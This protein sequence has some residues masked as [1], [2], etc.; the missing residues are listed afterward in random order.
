MK[1]LDNYTTMQIIDR[2]KDII[3]EDFEDFICSTI[4]N[5]QTISNFKDSINKRT[6]INTDKKERQKIA[7]QIVKDVLENSSFEYINDNDLKKQILEEII[8]AYPERIK[9]GTKKEI[10]DLILNGK[11]IEAYE[12]P[13]EKYKGLCEY[14]IITEDEPRTI[15]SIHDEKQRN[16]FKALINNVT[17]AD[18]ESIIKQKYEKTVI[19]VMMR[20]VAMKYFI[21]KKK[22]NIKEFKKLYENDDATSQIED[23]KA[24]KE[25]SN[26]IKEYIV[27]NFHFIDK[28][29]LLLNTASK[30]MLGLRVYSGEQINKVLIKKFDEA[31]RKEKI[32]NSILSLERIYRELIKG[33]Y[34][35]IKYKLLDDDGKII[36]ET[37]AKDIKEFLSRCTDSKYLS[38]SY[39]A[40]LRA[41]L[42]KGEFPEN[43]EELKI[44]DIG[45]E[46]VSEIV[47]N[48]E[49]AEDKEKKEKL[50]TSANILVK[51][52]LRNT[53][54]KKEDIID[55]YINGNA[56]LKL[57]ESMP[58]EEFPKEYFD[59]RFM[60]LFGEDVYL[61]TEETNAKLNRYGKL[62][63]MLR[64]QNH[65][66]TTTDDL[67]EKL[68][69]MFGE[70]FIP[71]II[72]ELYKTGVTNIEEAIQWLGGEFIA[73]QYEQG[74]I[75]PVDIREIYN[76]RI[77]SLEELAKM[78]NLLE[79]NTKKFMI[80]SSIF[81]E[82]DSMEIRQKLLEECMKVEDS[83]KGHSLNNGKQ[84]GDEENDKQKEKRYS[85]YITDP[86]ARF[87]LM[88]LLDRDYAYGMTDDG[89]A[90]VYLPDF[91]KVII[92]K[93]L[94]K[95]GEPYYGAATYVVDEKYF[96][97]NKSRVVDTNKIKRSNLNEDTILNGVDK[98][99]H[100]PTGWGKGIKRVLGINEEN[101]TPEELQ[102]IEEA[103]KAVEESRTKIEG[104]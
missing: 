69:N 31:E 34:D 51:Y 30:L 60:E 93:M 39:I 38:V 52:L 101:R 47:K 43:L 35:N 70:E 13:S 83:E 87:L 3:G 61:D 62:Y 74:T 21:D 68:A 89:H 53:D 88:Q 16:L 78:I 50:L 96:E 11:P 98:I 55:L 95:Y 17:A 90:V 84:N 23:E 18:I 85:K 26:L 86:V 7:Y 12:F 64:E 48:Y 9:T 14:E 65:I 103:I 63:S 58:L 56:N 92:E 41:N 72:G 57:I 75:K 28:E 42:A 97:E 37:E 19:T 104:E 5:N 29:A 82:A 81:P 25:I 77:I 100:S 49:E 44:A 10:K 80:I 79:D 54:V 2:Y 99:I 66:D 67:I 45:L 20:Q 36:I 46:D 8:R 6:F 94:S 73:N 24:E 27:E 59:N 102:Q 33:K 15:D 32:E 1:S 91:K 40:Q 22:M 71:D 76:K 4:I